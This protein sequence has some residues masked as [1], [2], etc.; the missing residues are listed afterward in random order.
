[1]GYCRPVDSAVPIADQASICDAHGPTIQDLYSRANCF[2]GTDARCTFPNH[3]T[4]CYALQLAFS[5][6]YRAAKS[7]FE[8]GPNG[9]LRAIH[10]AYDNCYVLSAIFLSNKEAFSD[11]Y[12]P[13]DDVRDRY[14]EC[15]T[16]TNSLLESIRT[17]YHEI[18]V[19]A[20]SFAYKDAF[21][22]TNWSASAT[23]TDRHFECCTNAVL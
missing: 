20:V 22:G 6:T 16:S 4:I 17:A 19:V 11:A 8:C 7:P 13:P 5:G 10:V 23:T 18:P 2:P 9:L 3:Y 21:S 1:M 14:S 15:G 12:G